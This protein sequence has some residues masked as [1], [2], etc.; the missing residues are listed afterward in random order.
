MSPFSPQFALALKLGALAIGVAL[1]FGVV[2]YRAFGFVDGRYTVGSPPPQPVP[3]SHKHHVMGEG[4][5]CRYC[6]VSV[7]T[8]AFAGLP[9]THTCMTCHALIYSDAPMLAPVR[10]SA[11]THTPLRWTRVTRLPDFVYFDHSIH[12]NKGIGCV[13][14]HGRVDM[15]PLTS[16]AHAMTMKWCL[17]CHRDPAPHLRPLNEITNMT[18]RPPRDRAA[19]GRQ[20]LAAYHIR[21]GH[22]TQ[23]SV[24]HR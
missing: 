14:C 24:C 1:V 16:T 19:L 10:A 6:H 23:C 20:L 9:D 7:E 15:M 3:F 22:L 12:V 17:A 8:S 18:W 11:A 13:T 4:I 2:G 5:D 21:V